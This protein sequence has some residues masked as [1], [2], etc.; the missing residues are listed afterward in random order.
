MVKYYTK[1]ECGWQSVLEKEVD[2]HIQRN[3]KFIDGKPSMQGHIVRTIPYG[4]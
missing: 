4:R 1:C 2:S 3:L